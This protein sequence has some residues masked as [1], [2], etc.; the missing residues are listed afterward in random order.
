MKTHL[1]LIVILSNCLLSTTYLSAQSLAPGSDVNTNLPLSSHQ[2]MEGASVDCIPQMLYIDQ[3]GDGFGSSIRSR[4]ACPPK[5]G[6]V[7]NNSDCN[8]ANASI[9]PD[10]SEVC[11]GIDDDCSGVADDHMSLDPD[12]LWQLSLGGQKDDKAMSIDYAANGSIYVAGESESNNGDV[13]GSHGKN[14]FWIVKLDVNG[15]VLWKKTLGGSNDD[16]AYAAKAT[17]DGGVAVAGST[18]STNGDVTGMHGTSDAWLVKLDSSGNLLWQKC[19]GG[20]GIDIAYDMALTTDGGYVLAGYTKS[21]DGD[22]TGSH[23]TGEYW[24]VKTNA[25]GDLEWNRTYG[26]S[27]FDFAHAIQQTTDGGYYVSGYARSS[28]GD[29]LLSYGQEDDWIL[30]LNAYGYIEWQKTYGG[31]GGEGASSLQQTADGGCVL[32]GITHSFNLDVVGNHGFEHDYW[33]VKIDSAGN[34]QWAVC[35]GGSASDDAHCIRQT[36][37]GG[38]IVVGKGGSNDGDATFNNGNHD[39]WVVKLN[40]EGAIQWQKSFGGS[41]DDQAFGVI[42]LP[43]GDFVVSGY[44]S[45]NDGDVTNNKGASDF[46]IFRI[47]PPPTTMF[48]ADADGDSFGN[49]STFVIACALPAGYVT[50]SSDCNDSSA[51]QHPGVYDICNGIDDNCNGIIDE[52]GIHATIDPLTTVTI[53]STSTLTYTANQDSMLTYQWFNEGAAITGAT[54]STYAANEDGRYSVQIS[55]GTCVSNSPESILKINP[56]HSEVTPSDTTYVCSATNVDYSIVANPGLTFQ[57]Y[58][59]G[60]LINAATKANYSTSE[61]GD[62]YVMISDILGC[63]FNSTTGTLKNYADPVTTIKVTGNLNICSTGSVKLSITQQTGSQYSWYKNGAVISGATKNSL[64]ITSE[65]TYNAL[66]TTSNGCTK[67]TNSKVVT[68]CGFERNGTETQAVWSVETFPNPSNGNFTLNIHS[69]DQL[70][71]DATLLVINSAGQVIMSKTLPVSDGLYEENIRL[72][73]QINPGLYFLR[74]VMADKE[75][76]KTIV[77]SK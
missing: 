25:T 51:N 12:R 53:C 19:Y 55:D 77:V 54:N 38:Y 30:K 17:S 61:P 49:K 9:N 39:H 59:S 35:L 11:N 43:A 48:Y 76:N 5:I 23:E 33:V 28:D 24:I 60:T 47:S 32:A 20:S 2:S 41:G 45:S 10:A 18:S 46:W 15:Q 29:V 62:Y 3:D 37:D 65:G 13:S 72:P 31:T 44:N 70:S 69:E 21:S 7:T 58:K 14:D 26:G 71:R 16:M 64:V 1:L 74:V 66:V 34:K 52:N 73:D 42:E 22:I 57:W 63:S 75:L 56:L 27:G 50:N 36:D 68:G 8:D 4:M 6:Y 67:Y 40:A